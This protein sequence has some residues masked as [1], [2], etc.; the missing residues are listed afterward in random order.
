MSDDKSPPTASGADDPLLRALLGA[1]SAPIVPSRPVVHTLDVD[2]D[3]VTARSL[4]E[5]PQLAG[6]LREVGTDVQQVVSAIVM[7]TQRGNCC[8]ERDDLGWLDATPTSGDEE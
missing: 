5:H 3:E 7:L 6:S 4:E 8:E 2:A 1:L